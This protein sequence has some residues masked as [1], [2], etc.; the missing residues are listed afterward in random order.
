MTS[1]N[2]VSI[3]RKA[4]LDD[5]DTIK[6]IADAH[7]DELGFVIRRALQESIERGELSV[8]IDG[9]RLAGFVE[10]RHRRDQQ[11]TLYHIAVVE[12][13]RQRGIG[14]LLVE[15]VRRD[16]LANGKNVIR[17]KCPESLPANEF[18]TR[19]GWQKIAVESGKRRR[20]VVWE[21]PLVL[22]AK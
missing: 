1:G 12:Q 11:T 4:V 18:Y 7:R 17:L 2:Q 16:A 14:R 10:Y 8:A 22:E 20:L 5:L 15:A 6:A 13:W 21:L 3:V 19:L 9:D